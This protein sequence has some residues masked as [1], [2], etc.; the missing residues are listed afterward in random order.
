M[1]AP[2]LRTIENQGMHFLPEG[3]TTVGSGKLLVGRDHDAENFQK[4]QNPQ[5][6]EHMQV[7]RQTK[8]PHEVERHNGQ[9]INNRKRAEYISQTGADFALK[10]RIFCGQIKAQQVLHR[11]DGN[12]EQV[13]K[14]EPVLVGLVDAG[15]GF[16]YQAEQ[17]GNN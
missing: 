6:L 12:R 14:L 5:R 2:A 15:N 3:A 8:Y 16:E 7:D 13:K 10:R 9:C 4:S 11:E 1:E 17:I